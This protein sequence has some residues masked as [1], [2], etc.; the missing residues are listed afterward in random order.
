MLRDPDAADNLT[1]ECFLKAYRR[2][3]QFRGEC[4]ARTWL[5]RIAV[6][7][8]RDHGKSRRLQFWRKLFARSEEDGM[9][10][11]VTDP[12]ASPERVLLAREELSAVRAAVAQLPGRQRAIF[13]LRFFEDMS[14]QEIAAAMALRP[15]TVKT[16]LFRAIAAVREGARG[17][18]S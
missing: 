15:G 14:I 5:L 6:N 12:Q 9:L 16:H 4:S 2:R 18:H 8:A 17:E 11:Q 7:L 3:G 1:Q 10:E 13:L